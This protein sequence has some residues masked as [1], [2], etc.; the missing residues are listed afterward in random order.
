MTI[1]LGSTTRRRLS[2]KRH[3]IVSDSRE[4]VVQETAPPDVVGR[5]GGR[6]TPRG[7]R[8]TALVPRVGRDVAAVLVDVLDERLGVRHE[9]GVFERR[10]RRARTRARRR[11][12]GAPRRPAPPADRRRAARPRCAVA[13]PPARARPAETADRAR[14]A[15]APP[16]ETRRRP[17]AS[18]TP[19]TRAPPARTSA[20]P[21]RSGPDLRRRGAGALQHVARVMAG[22]P[23]VT[24]DLQRLIDG[25]P[26]VGVD[27][28]ARCGRRRGSARTRSTA[29]RGRTRA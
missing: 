2:F 15:R 17:P 9:R 8:R 25:E 4:N 1:I 19:P 24:R 23:F 6:R 5:S 14:R 7:A 29:C 20:A 16:A 26:E 10:R 22:I 12:S 18:P 11:D 27:L 21:R 3:G 28:D 13:P